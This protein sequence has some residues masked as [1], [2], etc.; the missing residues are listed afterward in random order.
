MDLGPEQM[1]LFGEAERPQDVDASWQAVD[2]A[3][4]AIRAKFGNSAVGLARNLNPEGIRDVTKQRN[5]RFGPEAE[6]P[7]PD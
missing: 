7:T 1:A 3:V 4:D 5:E 6:P 2:E